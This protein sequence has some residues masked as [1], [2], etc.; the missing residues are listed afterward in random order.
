MN[1]RRARLL[2]VWA[3]LLALAW[4]GAWW[5][6]LGPAGASAGGLEAL[7]TG[8]WVVPG[9]LAAYLVRGVLLFP[10]TVLTL[11]AGW[12]LGPWLGAVVAWAGVLG[13]AGVAYALARFVRGDPTDRPAGGR[14][15]RWRA[16]LHRNAFRATLFARLASLPGDAVNVV[17]GAARA[18][19]GPFV[20]ATALGGAPGLLAV[21]WAG[22]ALEG[23]FAWRDAQ[24]DARWF[25]ASG[26]M[27]L[28][29]LGASW[30]AR[31][32]GSRA[33]RAQGFV[34]STDETA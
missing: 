31:R 16:S 13:S 15:A 30:V 5:S 1:A 11:F 33:D 21:V 14:L 34:K 27:L 18:P 28:V 29:G 9:L 17:A 26:A 23:T 22:A 10:S 4:G 24:V 25:L 12:A 8:R 19:F 32:W 7:A 3:V 20:A 6:G 2:G